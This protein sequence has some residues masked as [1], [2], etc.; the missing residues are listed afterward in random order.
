MTV[1]GMVL[2]AAVL[3]LSGCSPVQHLTS[4]E[5][6]DVNTFC[7]EGGTQANIDSGKALI[8]RF[9][10][11]A[12]VILFPREKDVFDKRMSIL[13]HN[14]GKW[15]RSFPGIPT[16]L[17]GESLLNLYIYVGIYFLNIPA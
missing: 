14:C 5:V 4:S 7:T 3:G 16:E 11:M 10:K 13:G 15:P 12:K 2:S 9:T 8:D 6:T 17:S 1:F